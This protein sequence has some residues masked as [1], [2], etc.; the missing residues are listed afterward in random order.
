MRVLG[1]LHT[2]CTLLVKSQLFFIFIQP[3]NCYYIF[4]LPIFRMRS[5][6]YGNTGNIVIRPLDYFKTIP[7]IS[8]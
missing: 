5:F 1:I 4:Y 7:V 3:C 6:I 2:N 8:S